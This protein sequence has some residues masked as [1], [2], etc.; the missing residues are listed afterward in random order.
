MKKKAMTKSIILRIPAKSEMC[1]PGYHLVK[2]HYRKCKNGG[3]T[4]VDIHKR[5]NRS[6]S[7]KMTYYPE[8]L[9]YLYWNSEKNFKKLK[10][11]KPFPG[12]HELDPIIQFWLEYWTKIFKRFP[13]IDPLL[14]KAL[15]AQESSFNLKADPKVSH[16]SAYGLMQIVD[17]TR[18]ILAGN[19]QSSVTMEFIDVS[20]EDL[21]DPVIN[22]A[23]GIRWMIVKFFNIEKKKGNK[24]HNTIKAYYGKDEKNNEEYLRKIFK[25]YNSSLESENSSK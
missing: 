25:H 24:L 3:K 21:E 5:R 19:I 14:I 15:I 1:E 4:W 9:L 23:V 16:S 6:S 22:I 12:Y 18:N 2:G 10:K 13:K 8:N 17:E 20:R 7:K 11:I